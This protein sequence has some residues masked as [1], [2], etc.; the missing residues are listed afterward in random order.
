MKNTC[1]QYDTDIVRKMIEINIIFKHF[2]ELCKF[3]LTSINKKSNTVNC[4]EDIF[5]SIQNEQV[6]DHNQVQKLKN[7]QDS[8]MQEFY[9]MEKKY[10]GIDLQDKLKNIL[11]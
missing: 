2:K 10:K 5:K 7:E 11:I 6:I 3:L 8:I 4:L 1:S 9:D